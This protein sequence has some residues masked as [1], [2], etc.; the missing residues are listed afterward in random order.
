[1][2]RRARVLIHGAKAGTLGRLEA[3]LQE[4]DADGFEANSPA[5]LAEALRQNCVDLALADAGWEV[6]HLDGLLQ[7]L[8]SVHEVPIILVADLPELSP[9]ALGV[10]CRL[11]ATLIV[12]PTDHQILATAL[13]DGLGLRVLHR[14]HRQ[15][16][17]HW[18]RGVERLR[19]CRERVRSLRRALKLTLERVER[20]EQ[21]AVA[22][23]RRRVWL[24]STIGHHLRTPVHEVVLCCNL[25]EAAGA[26]RAPTAAD[27][28][29]LTAGLRESVAWLQD[30]VDDLVDIARLDL[31]NMPNQPA[32][33]ALDTL[34][35]SPLE[36]LRREAVRK[37]LDFRT[38]VEPIDALLFVDGAKF[39]RIVTNLASNAVKFT[40]FGHISLRATAD[41]EFGVT[42]IVADTG[43]GIP[44][45]R[46]NEIFQDFAQVDNP[47]R[48]R[49]KGT[50]LGLALCRR[51]VASLGG[52]L[53]VHS[54]PGLGS[55]FTLKT[56][57]R[58][59][60]LPRNFAP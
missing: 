7:E 30:L 21:E 2:M 53:D 37:G 12:K 40:E 56:P 1:M 57:C 17:S 45:D 55:T 59:D 25:M 8:H 48:S 28:E 54:I 51:L 16:E 36:D 3:L 41:P 11:N 49:A 52:T 27:W 10:A 26:N 35:G 14:D 20:L 33:V 4:A 13:R 24:L 6:D 46:V 58:V 9:R 50:G 22:E 60:L 43:P 38:I 34:V 44:A 39:V 19:G 47:E 32:P 31:G 5:D 42:L 15:C 23:V 29:G 18:S